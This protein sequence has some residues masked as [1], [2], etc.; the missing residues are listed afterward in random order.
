[1]TDDEVVLSFDHVSKRF[2]SR[3]AAVT[4]TDDVS[5]LV[6]RGERVALLG[7]NGAGKTTCMDL[8]CGVTAPTSGRVRALGTS[9]RLAVRE[10]RLTAVLQTGGLLRDL[11]VRETV[12]VIAALH[13]RR[14]RTE[15]VLAEAG[16]T[17]L[18]KRLV[19]RCSGGE[20][21]RLKYALAL[22][23]D[24]EVLVLDEPASGLDQEGRAALWEHVRQRALHGTTIIH[25]TH[26]LDEVEPLAD[27]VLLLRR[28][29]LVADRLVSDLTGA[30][31]QR[32]IT[33][34]LP[35]ADVLA[36]SVQELTGI[37][38]VRDDGSTGADI[39]LVADARSSD[40]VIAR[41]LRDHGGSELMAGPRTLEAAL[42]DLT[43]E[44]A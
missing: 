38:G 37:R 16:L 21:Q 3:T 29:R 6:R 27:R 19:G 12:Q 40:E 22:I 28:G 10:G 35:G 34:R 33:A 25:S 43:D 11:T 20:Q 39:R 5:A 44:V 9:P 36:R 26:H 23:P 2:T 17:A 30:G 42:A 14:D 18:T 8:M 1:M 15:A 4:A 31:A 32:M 41:L 24:P 7:A 13:R